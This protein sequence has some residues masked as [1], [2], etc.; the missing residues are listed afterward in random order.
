MHRYAITTLLLA[1]NVLAHPGHGAP[2]VH[3]HGW[4]YLLLIAA[5]ALAVAAWLKV[6]K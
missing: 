3:H 1:G 4:E 2:P 5:M 6:R